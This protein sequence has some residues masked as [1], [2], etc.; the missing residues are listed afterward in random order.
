MVEIPM[1]DARFLR[2]IYGVTSL[3][4]LLNPDE[5]HE[6]IRQHYPAALH[7]RGAAANVLLRLDIDEA[8]AVARAEAIAP[9]RVPG[10]LVGAVLVNGD[11]DERRETEMPTTD[12]AL[13]RAAE[14]AVQVARFAPAEL[15]GHAVPRP[16]F[17]VTIRFAPLS[18]GDGPAR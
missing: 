5:L 13:M 7:E 10:E 3:P 9:P 6:S 11:S 14:A 12:P 4:Q 1:H 2:E 16:D 17:R 18:E 8:G 15:D